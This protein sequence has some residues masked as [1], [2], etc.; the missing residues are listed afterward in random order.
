[1]LT[2][3]GL[4]IGLIGAG[5]A[6]RALQGMLFG[7]AP[8]DPATYVVVSLLFGLAAVFAAYLPARRATKVDALV[9]LRSE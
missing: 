3:I 2:S 7:I 5:I 4:T 8:L 9:A 1:V 6:T